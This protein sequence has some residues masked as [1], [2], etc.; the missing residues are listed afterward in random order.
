M[1]E[2][3]RLGKLGSTQACRF[4]HACRRGDLARLAARTSDVETTIDH[5]ASSGS[6]D[7]IQSV[8]LSNAIC[9]QSSADR[10]FHKHQGSLCLSRFG[11]SLLGAELRRDLLVHLS[12]KIDLSLLK[13]PIGILELLVYRNHQFAIRPL[14]A[15]RSRLGLP[16]FL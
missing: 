12:A 11:F 13:R 4:G 2:R 15:L 6:S 16:Q 7:G 5:L 14:C 9:E 3:R 8:D 1:G 10:F